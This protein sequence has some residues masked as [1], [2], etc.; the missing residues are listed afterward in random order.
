MST[1]EASDFESI[2]P[3][4]LQSLSEL[5]KEARETDVTIASLENQLS[6]KKERLRI[7]VEGLLPDIMMELGMSE[8]KLTTGEKLIM[9]KY[10]SASIKDENQEAA[11][12]WLRETNND[13]II[14]NEVKGSFGKGQDAEAKQVMEALESMVPGLFSLKT[15]VHP[16]T[17]KS[18]V[19]ERIEG[20]MELPLE[21]FSVFI[22]NKIKIK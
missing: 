17:L 19:K 15:N 3:E 5:A 12:K 18:F 16:M 20:G 8:L 6:L 14:K 4:K 13:S 7:I 22:G 10:Y 2:S 9:S 11:F 21:T 1:E